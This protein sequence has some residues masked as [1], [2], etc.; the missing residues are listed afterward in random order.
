MIEMRHK[1]TQEKYAEAVRLYADTD[2]TITDI[3]LRCDISR[4]A[5]SQYL[6][7]HERELMLKRHE[8]STEGKNPQDVKIIQPGKQS[9][10]AHEKYHKAVEACD[11][12]EYIKLNVSQIAR[13]FN[14]TP[15]GLHN[16]MRIH[17]PDIIPNREKIRG[18]LGLTDNTP[19][20]ARQL[21]KRQYAEAVELYRKSNMA[22]PEIAER[23]GV[24]ERGLAQHLRSY[25]KDIMRKKEQQRKQAKTERKKPKGAMLGNGKKNQPTPAV[26]MKYAAAFALYKSTAM[27]MKDIV[28]LTGVPAEGFRFYIHKWHK[29]LVFERSGINADEFDDINITK[30]RTKIKTVAAKYADAI[31][32]LKECPRPIAV[33]AREF[34]HNPEAFRNYLHKHEPKTDEKLGM[35][36]DSN[37]NR[38]THSAQEKYSEAMRLYATTTET[39]KSIC[40]RLG[41]NATSTNGYIHRH[42]PEVSVLHKSLLN[43][44]KKGI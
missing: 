17:Y 1:A 14:V 43:K 25:H 6:R 27:K 7:R 12:M 28:E 2:M 39:L 3:A 18:R 37:G 15:T 32:S 36:R 22:M 16:F 44:D 5:F 31:K 19:R 8:I 38:V 42:R 21:S 30:A 23:C 13:K 10:K 20:G 4:K 26:V 29:S 9:D 35:I 34:G 33:V 41:I 24:S 11:S 40:A